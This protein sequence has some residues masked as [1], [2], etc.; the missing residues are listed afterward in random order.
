MR[1]TGNNRGDRYGLSGN[2]K[3]SDPGANLRKPRW[4]LERL[5]KFEKN[6]YQETSAVIRRSSEDVENFREDHYI[7]VKGDKVPKPIFQFDE[8]SFPDQILSVMKKNGWNKPTP[9][10]AQ[11]W[12]MA[13]SGRDVVGI[14]QTGS[15]KTACFLLPGMVHIKAQPR[16]ER[17]DGPI[18]LVMVPTRE[19]AQQ[20]QQV[21]EEFGRACGFRNVCCYGG[22]P[23]GPQIRDLERGAEICI[24]TPGRLLDFLED[25]RVNLKR[26]TYLV[27][28]E[29]DRMLDMGFE[30]QIRKVVDQVRP[31][32]QTLMWSATWP[33]EVQILAKD[34]LRNYIQVNVG[35]LELHA[36]HNIKQ[37][38]EILEDWQ[39]ESRLTELLRDFGRSKTLVF[40]E[41]KRKV[42]ELTW[43]LRRSGYQAVAIHG[44]KPQREREYVLNGKDTLFL[45]LALSMTFRSIFQLFIQTIKGPDCVFCLTVIHTKV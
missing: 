10:Q 35:A 1:D 9:I 39:K 38:I 37:Y 23:K 25:R 22:A 13:L 15:G 24:A 12:P 30:P 11:G 28:D 18:V 14:A 4:D 29:A 3:Y 20:V 8:V 40:V 16:L 6:F 32:R 44:D 33:K 7:T 45:V 42:D 34:F 5:L 36:N 2:S 26:T 19:L 17:G 21:A 43:T 27:M 41:T 31:D